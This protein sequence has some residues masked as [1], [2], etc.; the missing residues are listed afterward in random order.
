MSQAIRGY[1]YFILTDLFTC[2]R[3][4][5]YL[6]F[7]LIV[8][9]KP[10]SSVYGKFLKIKFNIAII[11]RQILFVYLLNKTL[12]SQIFNYFSHPDR[13][14]KSRFLSSLFALWRTIVYTHQQEIYS[15][16]THNERKRKSTN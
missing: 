16:L 5:E 2:T 9:F 8:N 14:C 6:H 1:I 11:I 3:Q 12:F 7:I 15:W 13:I 10:F 4:G